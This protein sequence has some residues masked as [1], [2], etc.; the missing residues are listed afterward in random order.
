MDAV[1]IDK[2]LWAMRVYKTR[3]DA[4]QACR[5]SAVRLNQNPVK[6][7]QKVHV[8]D[9]IVVRTTLLTRTLKVC[10][11]TDKRQPARLLPEYIE[12]QTPPEAHTLAMEKKRGRN[13]F[14]P[15]EK[16]ARPKKIAAT[17]SASSNR[18]FRNDLSY[19]QSSV[20]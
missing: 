13:N 19:K 10:A 12:D 4:A 1:R 18:I 6:P 15:L 2:W 8:G 14:K 20:Y 17:W 9:C 11:L 16:G 7:A 5:G 3:A